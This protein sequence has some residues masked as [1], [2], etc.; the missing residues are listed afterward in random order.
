[1]EEFEENMIA[2][3]HFYN[4]ERKEI[5]Q[6]QTEWINLFNSYDIEHYYQELKPLIDS[7]SEFNFINPYTN[8]VNTWPSFE[9]YDDGRG[10]LTIAF[11]FRNRLPRYNSDGNLI[12]KDEEPEYVYPFVIA[13]IFDINESYYEPIGNDVRNWM[14]EKYEFLLKKE[15][16]RE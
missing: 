1:M 4:E 6:L 12:E 2:T 9:I 8:H 14:K 11:L 13:R 7:I 3:C 16:S 15:S 10:P 5:I